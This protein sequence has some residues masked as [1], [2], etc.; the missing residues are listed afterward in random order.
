[1]IRQAM[2]LSE[3]EEIVS[4]HWLRNRVVQLH[5]GGKLK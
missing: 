3:F 1:M 4:L 5:K 2:N